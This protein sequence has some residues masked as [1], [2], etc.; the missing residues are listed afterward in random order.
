M[1][2]VSLK[3]LIFASI[4][5]LAAAGFGGCLDPVNLVAFVEDPKVA[6]II[7]KSQGKVILVDSGDL[8]PGNGKITGLDPNEYYMIE[9]WDEDAPSEL[10]DSEDIKFVTA[11]GT[12]A[13]FTSIGRL[14][15]SEITGLTNNN[16]Y[17]VTSAKPLPI[18]NFNP[19]PADVVSNT[20]VDG[21]V[22]LTDAAGGTNMPLPGLTGYFV[23]L[24]VSP[25]GS[26]PWTPDTVSG[27]IT[28]ESPGTT[29]DY[30]FYDITLGRDSFYELQVKINAVPPPPPTD[31][32]LTITLTAY[33]HTTPD[34]TTFDF[35]SISPVTL[36]WSADADQT[37]S[38]TVNTSPFAAPGTW[39]FNGA[40]LGAVLD[41]DAIN[42]YN[43][44]KPAN[45]MIDL[46]AAE[47]SY[48][49]TYEATLA[50]TGGTLRS[51]PFT[52]KIG[53]KP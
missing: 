18:A 7:E 36:T 11:D 8:K 22:T 19:V 17:R 48:E 20:K 30:V 43:T 50:G 25:A 32:N 47:M 1:K 44:G 52:I 26:P 4:C 40:S 14:T 33:V 46:A 42:G 15:G 39:F 29:T 45:E 12:C 2:G 10:P 35:G 49:F 28:L 31:T 51:A 9:R 53:V 5:A 16:V 24:P 37:V 6:S 34:G 41:N 13:E 38:I 23:T 27:G 21:K 3:A